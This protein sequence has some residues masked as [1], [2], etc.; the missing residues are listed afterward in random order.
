MS[1]CPADR[2]QCGFNGRAAECL[3]PIL[4]HEGLV[5]GAHLSL[6]ILRLMARVLRCLFHDAVKPRLSAIIN[7]Y[8]D[9]HTQFVGRYGGS[10][11]PASIGEFEEIVTGLNC[12]ILPGNIE[13]PVSKVE[14]WQAIIASS[15]GEQQ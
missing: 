13:A 1:S 11:E 9:G 4:I 2:R 5:E 7:K 10:R 6:Q 15:R 12:G 14:T 8:V 3:N